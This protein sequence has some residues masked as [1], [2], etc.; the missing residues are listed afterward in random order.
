LRTPMIGINN[1]ELQ[2]F[3]TDLNTTLDLLTDL[4]SDRTVVTESGIYKPDDVA[5]MRRNDVSA[6][7][8][9]EVFM[10]ADDPG[11]KL[12]ELFGSP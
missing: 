6:F 12:E 11:A 2:T 3:N 5:L 9:G 1:R 7:L 8:V 10:G 4:Y